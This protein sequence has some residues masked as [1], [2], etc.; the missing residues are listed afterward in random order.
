M[1]PVLTYAFIIWTPYTVD[2][3]NKLETIQRRLLRHLAYRFH[4]PINRFDH[5][6]SSVFQYYNIH[7]VKFYKVF[8]FKL[9]KLNTGYQCQS[10][11]SLFKIKSYAYPIRDTRVLKEKNCSSASTFNCYVLLD[12]EDRG[13]CCILIYPNTKQFMRLNSLRNQIY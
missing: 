9:L 1:L 4:V 12:L 13:I 7:M 11:N 5:D 3:I 8:V 6:F 2:S 10:V